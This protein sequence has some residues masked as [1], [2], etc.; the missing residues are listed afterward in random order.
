MSRRNQFRETNVDFGSMIGI[1]TKEDNLTETIVKELNEQSDSV[2]EVLTASPDKFIPYDDEKLRLDLHHG[3]DR[4]R[5]KESIKLNGIFTPVICVKK[6]EKLMILSGHNR[7]DIAKELDIEV[8][9]LL[10]KDLTEDEIKLICI[11]DN[12]IHRQRSDYKP[13]QLAYSIKV[14][15]D[16]ERHQGVTLST[17]Y[18]KLSGNKIGEEHGLSR[19][20]I[21]IYLKLN[22]LNDDIKTMVDNKNIAIKTAYE[23]SFFDKEFQTLMV[24]YINKYKISAKNVREIR[25][26]M[27][28]KE[29]NDMESKKN[30]LNSQILQLCVPGTQS[31]KLD[32]RNIRKFIPSD[33][34]DENAEDYVIEALKF[35]NE[36]KL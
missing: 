1:Q 17:G 16:T 36:N 22:E 6:D 29:I 11:D 12:L 7:V 9:Y 4:E 18:S 14:K 28:E 35:Y 25:Q 24:E 31:H 21:N 33:I 10:K 5:L 34:K 32:F 19:K 13:M 30:F 23:I 26:N 2:N 15:M 20:M 8:P 27:Q 3:E